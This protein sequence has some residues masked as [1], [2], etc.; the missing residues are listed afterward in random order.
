M[1]QGEGSRRWETLDSADATEICKVQGGGGGE[2]SLIYVLAGPRRVTVRSSRRGTTALMRPRCW[3]AKGALRGDMGLTSS[4]VEKLGAATIV[5]PSIL[6]APLPTRL[7]Y[8]SSLCVPVAAP[9][10]TR[11]LCTT[12]DANS[13]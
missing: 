4:A 12:D 5:S 8:T 1:R 9:G 11:E 10:T 7:V 3:A 13:W 6:A 2:V